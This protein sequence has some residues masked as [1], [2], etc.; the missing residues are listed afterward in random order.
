MLYLKSKLG[1]TYE[2]YDVDSSTKRVFGY[3]DIKSLWVMNQVV[4]YLI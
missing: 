2:I 3:S 4:T 1:N